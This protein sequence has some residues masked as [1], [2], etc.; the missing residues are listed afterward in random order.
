MAHPGGEGDAGESRPPPGDVRAGGRR[1]PLGQHRPD[2]LPGV[3]GQVPGPARG[4][5]RTDHLV[6]EH[7]QGPPRHGAGQ[8][9]GTRWR[10]PCAAGHAGRRGDTQCACRFRASRAAARSTEE[11][12]APGEC[13]VL[14]CMYLCGLFVCIFSS[15]KSVLLTRSHQEQYDVVKYVFKGN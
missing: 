7:G 15:R 4:P 6:R 2:A 11:T 8:G 10:H 13:C 14:E 3:G 12:G 9:Q 1:V 5:R